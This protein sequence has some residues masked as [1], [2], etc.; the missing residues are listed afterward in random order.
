[1]A[2]LNR[3]D[4]DWMRQTFIVSADKMDDIEF[5]RRTLR[6][7]DFGFTDTSLGGNFVINPPPQLTRTADVKSYGITAFGASGFENKGMGRW[8]E[9]AIDSRSQRLYLRFGVPQF[10]SLL[11]FFANM[12]SPGMAIMARTGRVPSIMYEAGKMVGTVA[13]LPAQ[14]MIMVD[15]ALNYM[16]GKPS[17]RFYSLNQAMPLYWDAVNTIVNGLAV[18]MGIIPRAMTVEERTRW[19][20]DRSTFT[21]EDMQAYYKVQPDI[22]HRWGGIDVYWIAGK[23]QRKANR[24]NEKL[25]EVMSNNYLGKGFTESTN[26]KDTPFLTRFGAAVKNL[27]GA[28]GSPTNPKSYFLANPKDG[29]E[30]VDQKWTAANAYLKAYAERTDRYYALDKANAVEQ[31][32]DRVGYDETGKPAPWWNAMTSFFHG[33]NQDGSQF[34][35]LRVDYSGPTT[36]SISNEAGESEISQKINSI[37][38]ANRAARTNLAD[39]KIMGGVVGEAIGAAAQGASD[40]AAGAAEKFGVAGAAAL[41]G[42]AQIEIPKVWMSSRASLPRLDFTLTLRSAYGNKMARLLHLYVP[43]ACI[44]A[45]GSPLATGK[46]S[47]TSPFICEAYCRGMMQSRLAMM[48]NIN[49]T[50]GAGNIGFTEDFE[51]LQLDV[52]FSLVDLSTVFFMPIA[53]QTSWQQTAAVGAGQLAAT[54]PIGNAVGNAVGGVTGTNN[55]GDALGELAVLGLGSTWDDE[56]MM[57]DYLSLLGGLSLQDQT[58]AGRRLKLA[59]TRQMVAG[60]NWISPSRVGVHAMGSKPGRLISILYRGTDR[61]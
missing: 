11:N 47:Y 40:F 50:H 55:A 41:A 32:G 25:D 30:K 21:S 17:S 9:E 16:L 45:G 53:P 3:H 20:D 28:Y 60:K 6:E 38:S 1:M 8:Y 22:F 26:T 37:A 14:P 29:T 54:T 24:F 7:V 12:Y 31:G 27:Y 15:R 42:N 18:N 23:A 10:N 39:G 56:N 19:A 61:P 57:T 35:G 44:L 34:L 48:D 2:T 59:I 52:A 43:L 46:Q 4:R 36:L 49:V 58:Q 33:E 13:T 51:P 5:E